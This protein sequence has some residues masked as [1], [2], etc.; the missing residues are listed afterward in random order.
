MTEKPDKSLD[1]VVREDG[2]YPLEAFGF[3]HDGLA[4]AVKGVYGEAAAAEQ[5]SDPQ[6]RRPRHVTGRQLCEALRE[7][8]IERWGMLARTVLERWN[9]RETLDFGRMVY[10]L[11]E[12][13]LMQKT[14]SDSL[15]DFRA[16]YDFESA[17]S[18]ASIFKG[19]G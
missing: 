8:G 17:F 7:E 16:V 4:R 10:L 6:Q 12:N 14:E 18:P 13:G 5:A 9:V 3:L 15:E 11:V 1:E 2:R 19:E